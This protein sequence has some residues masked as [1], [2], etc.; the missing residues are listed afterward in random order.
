[1]FPRVQAT[2]ANVNA[3]ADAGQTLI[4]VAKALVLDLK[5]G[6]GVTF[7]PVKG[8]FNPWINRLITSITAYLAAVLMWK[9]RELLPLPSNAP[10]QPL[11]DLAWMEDEQ[12]PIR[13]DIDPEV[14][15]YPA[16]IAMFVGGPYDG[17]QFVVDER[18]LEL[19]LKGGHL[20]K[21][22][23][24]QFV[25]TTTTLSVATVGSTDVAIHTTS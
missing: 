18:R 24:K 11:L 16:R 21:W 4:G 22:D 17:K 14:D 9:I 5:D 6:A 1:M 15:T 25:H 23:G 13:V 12:I 20:Y 10:P 3:A 7:R 2:L 8:K 19:T